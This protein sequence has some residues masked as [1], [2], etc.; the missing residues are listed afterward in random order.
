MNKRKT[1]K[2]SAI[3]RKARA[4]RLV[5]LLIGISPFRVTTIRAIGT[6]YGIFMIFQNADLWRELADFSKL[7]RR[8]SVRGVLSYAIL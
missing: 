5:A 6:L 8:V 3:I 4:L 2:P 7:C 1:K